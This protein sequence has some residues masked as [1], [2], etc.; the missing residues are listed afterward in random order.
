MEVEYNNQALENKLIFSPQ[1][2][3]R[4]LLLVFFG[5][6]NSVLATA[7]TLPMVSY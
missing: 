3:V 7:Q 6:E 4:T 1:L 2:R 5:V